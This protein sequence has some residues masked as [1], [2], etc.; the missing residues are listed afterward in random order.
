VHDFVGLTLFTRYCAL[1]DVFSWVL[2][3][4]GWDKG[5]SILSLR[6]PAMDSEMMRPVSGFPWLAN[7][8]V[9]LPVRQGWLAPGWGQCFDL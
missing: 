8:F 1:Y 5:G 9:A 7:F 3:T 4:G 2:A 6:S